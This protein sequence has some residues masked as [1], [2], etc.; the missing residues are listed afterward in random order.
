MEVKEQKS[1]VVEN[2]VEGSSIA[3]EPYKPAQEKVMKELG[4]IS[5]DIAALDILLAGPNQSVDNR[6]KR[7]QLLKKQDCLKRRL[8]RLRAFAKSQKKYRKTMKR[9]MIEQKIARRAPGRP[10]LEDS[11]MLNYPRLF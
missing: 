7:K 1:V 6:L 10:A 9:K 4:V 5:L 2:S 11:G 3:I 8:N